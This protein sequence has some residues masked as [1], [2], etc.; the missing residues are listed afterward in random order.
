MT[1]VGVRGLRNR[2][3]EILDLVAG[4]A[5]VIVT[6]DGRPAARLAPLAA[7]SLGTEAL[8]E[9][10]RHLPQVDPAAL[11]ADIERTADASL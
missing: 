5:E 9:R 7:S 10:R 1:I 11:R 3:G 6:R 2:G 4:G 8:V